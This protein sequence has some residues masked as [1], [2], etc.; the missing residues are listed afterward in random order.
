[1]VS[2]SS[3]FHNLKKKEKKKKTNNKFEMTHCASQT[4]KKSNS[5]LI[6]NLAAKMRAMF[7]VN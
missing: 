2:P 7:P 4:Y 3:I 5:S 1:M 6:Y